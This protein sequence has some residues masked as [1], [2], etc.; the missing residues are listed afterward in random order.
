MKFPT[1]IEAL[2]WCQQNLDKPVRS[3]GSSRSIWWS[4][5]G[6]GVEGPLVPDMI[7]RPDGSPVEWETVEEK[8]RD[9]NE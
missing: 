1:I 3:H 4:E 5:Y 8:E 2:R 6:F 9:T 7:I